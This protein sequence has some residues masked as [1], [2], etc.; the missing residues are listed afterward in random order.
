MLRV[1]QNPECTGIN[2]GLQL[3]RDWLL[4]PSSTPMALR[5]IEGRGTAHRDMGSSTGLLCFETRATARK[6]CEHDIQLRLHAQE[7]QSFLT[8]AVSKLLQ[9]HRLYMY[10]TEDLH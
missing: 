5:K 1:V 9:E 7:G 4:L 8:L 3:G 10:T 6:K 2:L